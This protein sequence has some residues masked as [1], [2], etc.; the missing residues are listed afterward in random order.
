MTLNE[1]RQ[2]QWFKDADGDIC[3][4]TQIDYD[5]G[6]PVYFVFAVTTN[7]WYSYLIE[8][9][10]IEIELLPTPNYDEIFATKEHSISIERV[11]GCNCDIENALDSSIARY[12]KSG[13]TERA[14][15][16][17]MI[18]KMIFEEKTYT[19]ANSKE[20]NK[21]LDLIN[22]YFCDWARFYTWN[23]DKTSVDITIN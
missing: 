11:Y 4:L 16:L 14:S 9:Q 23:D 2:G 15:N 13:D 3:I 6:E 1:L 10:N 18:E 8:S 19:T 5:S 21:M 12:V 20:F 7:D 17:A 22:E